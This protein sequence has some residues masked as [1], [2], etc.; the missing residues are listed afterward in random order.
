MIAISFPLLAA[1]C[2]GGGA[3][4]A[5]SAM[6]PVHPAAMIAVGTVGVVV[7]LLLASGNSLTQGWRTDRRYLVGYLL[8]LG[9]GLSVGAGSVV[10]K[11]AL[12]VY[13][14]PLAVT[15]LGML[16]A[17]ALIVPAAGSLAIRNPAVR[18]CD[19]KSPGLVAV[20]GLSTAIARL[21]QFFAIRRAGVVVVA[22][23]LATFPLWT[24]LLSHAFIARLERITPR[25]I[26]GALLAVAGVVA[27][28]LGGR[29]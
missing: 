4:S 25:L 12:G 27:V 18:D 19:R 11:Q 9:A 5:R 1:I 14:S 15:V 3:V 20:S 2:L 13:D 23:I 7:A 10:G 8:A 6:P 29:I 22:P 16:V 21:S 28:T 17:M 26:V 24:L